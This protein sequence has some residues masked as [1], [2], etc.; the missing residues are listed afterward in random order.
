MLFL[1]RR[2]AETLPRNDTP[3]LLNDQRHR[4]RTGDLVALGCRPASASASS[5]AAAHAGGE[6]G[7]QQTQRSHDPE[8][9]ALALSASTIWEQQQRKQDECGGARQCLREC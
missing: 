5:T 6:H 8:A 1:V 2:S 3:R 4:A 9:R 7:K